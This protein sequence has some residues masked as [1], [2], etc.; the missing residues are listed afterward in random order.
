[1]TRGR[2]WVVALA[3]FTLALFLSACSIGRGGDDDGGDGSA[4]SGDEAFANYKIGIF[5]DTTTNNFWAYM[6][7]ESSVW[8]AYVLA[9]TKPAFFDIAYPIREGVEAGGTVIPDVAG[10]P[11]AEPVEQ[12]GKWV[13][14]QSIEP[15]LKWSDGRPITARDFVFTV[16]TVHRLELG[17]N[18]LSAY[19][20]AAD[21]TTGI[22]KVEAVDD[23]TVRITF[24]RRPGLALW[25]HAVGV[26]GPWM[27]AHFW[28]DRAAD[29][30]D[31]KGLYG[32]DGRRDPSAGP[33]VFDA[34]EEG[35]FAR[36]VA[37]ETFSDTGETVRLHESGAVEVDDETYGDGETGD[38]VEEYTYGP[39]FE[40]Q[41]FSL[42]GS[43]DAAVLALRQGK[44]D[45]LLNPLGMQRGL[46]DQV[47]NDKNLKAVVNPTYG[48]RYLAFNFRKAPMND[49]A[50]RQALATMI[51]REFMAESVLQGVA[52]P[53][54]TM[55]PEGNAAWYDKAQADQIKDQYL[56]EDAAERVQKAV[57]ILEDAGYTWSR[58]PSYNADEGFVVAGQGLKMPNGRA[59]PSLEILAPPAGYDPLRATYAI[60]IER[61]ARELGIPARANPT[62]FNI[63]V[64]KVFTTPPAKPTFDMFI[65][66]W[67]LGN[68]AMP[69][70]YESFWHSRHDTATSGG[71]NA[72]GFRNQ[73]FDRLADRFLAARDEEEAKEIVWQMEEILAEELPYVVLFDTPILEFYRNASLKYPFDRTLG[74]IQFLNAVPG[75][76]QAAAK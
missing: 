72:P 48:F 61:W 74:G 69:T 6:D 57:Q 73:Q 60:W 24:N 49:K 47:V 51:D 54:Y 46:Q 62:G 67:S 22:E 42:Y 14:E 55:M 8:N 16:N 66:G 41:T 17:G 58:K 11:P 26:D 38:P 4:R 43:Q 71:N 2:S 63:I 10:G 1:M 45:F 59:V 23:R 52:F 44:V 36:N 65:L 3:A 12:D 28:A 56:I 76:V 35:A 75:L 20:K 19:P 34:R 30:K 9:P 32:L 39:Y 25:P 33:V 13:V 29:V 27:P 64:D 70:F 37:N 5:E 7:P 31:A 53:L 21:D 18:W 68:P 40:S 50:F 15:G